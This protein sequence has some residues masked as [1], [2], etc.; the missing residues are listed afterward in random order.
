[1]VHPNIRREIAERFHRALPD[2]IRT[3][4]KGRGIPATFIERQ[5]LGWNSDRI[6]IP[7]FGR[8]RE[9]LGFR[10]AKG[11]DDASDSAEMISELGLGTELY[12]WEALMR[13]PQRIVICARE[14][15][16]LVLEANGFPA[17]ASTG[18]P[19]VFLDEWVP[20]FAPVKQVYICFDRD[21]RG[22]AAAKKVQR[23]LPH[24]R[25][26]TLSPQVGLKG[27]VTEFFV[28][29]QRR[30]IDFEVLLADAKSEENDGGGDAPASFR[31]FLPRHRS[32]RRRAE[33]VKRAVRLHVVV[34][35]YTELQ[36]SGTGLVGHCPFHDDRQLSFAVFP[37]N[38]TYSC[39]VCGAEGDVVKFLM[40][41]E[42]LT[43]GQALEALERFEYTHELYGTS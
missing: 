21:L 7:V 23:L 30:K 17:V 1:M 11:P 9:V 43:V 15:D 25:I 37:A 10:Y 18:G 13:N 41:K 31:S 34:S 6:T 5:L 14:F 27:G 20:Y 29:L 39:S 33:R 16:R 38:D 8:D 35:Q 22:A 24:A 26:V 2:A 4:L 19:D 28:G 42:S 40:D 3:Y 36:A 32:V 12:G